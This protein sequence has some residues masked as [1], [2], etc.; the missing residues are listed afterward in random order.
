MVNTKAIENLLS[1]FI[2]G[3]FGYIIYLKIKGEDAM[4]SIKEKIKGGENGRFKFRR[5]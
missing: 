2:L 1:L 4:S 3:G 5:N